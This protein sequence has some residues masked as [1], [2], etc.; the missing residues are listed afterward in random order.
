MLALIVEDERSIALE[1]CLRE[2]IEIGS[3]TFSGNM[4]K[5]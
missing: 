2:D 1:C 3:N 4:S 5:I